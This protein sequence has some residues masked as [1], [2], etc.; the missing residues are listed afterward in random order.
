MTK[1]ILTQLESTDLTSL[2]V[3]IKEEQDNY[4]LLNNKY[5]TDYGRTFEDVSYDIVDYQSA[6]NF[7]GYDVIIRKKVGEDEYIKA[8]STG[9]ESETRSLEWNLI[10]KQNYGIIG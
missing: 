5:L 3:A 6:N 7:K 1:E 2:L 9:V 8:I 10:I 4:F